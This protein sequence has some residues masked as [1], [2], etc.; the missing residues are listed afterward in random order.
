MQEVAGV[1]LSALV[2][3]LRFYHWVRSC[4]SHDN[5]SDCHSLYF[6]SRCPSWVETKVGHRRMILSTKEIMASAFKFTTA[7][8]IRF[9]GPE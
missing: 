8:L 5:L 4:S 9:S 3:T 1:S 6:R 2:D 7:A